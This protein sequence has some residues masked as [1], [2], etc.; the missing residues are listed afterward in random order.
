MAIQTIDVSSATVSKAIPEKPI[1]TMLFVVR[2][3]TLREAA[4]LL[5]EG[6]GQVMMLSDSL[7]G[8]KPRAADA[9]NIDLKEHAKIRRFKTEEELQSFKAY[10]AGLMQRCRDEKSGKMP[11]FTDAGKDGEGFTYT[12]DSGRASVTFR[13]DDHSDGWVV[14]GQAKFVNPE[15]AK[16]QLVS[17]GYAVRILSDTVEKAAS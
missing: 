1:V 16:R 7:V 9:L 13:K 17:K 15:I 8:N 3:A 4:V 12:V 5:R 2:C 14:C 10:M 6:I 11:T